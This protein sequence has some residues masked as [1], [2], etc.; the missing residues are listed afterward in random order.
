MVTDIKSATTDP[1]TGNI[2]SIQNNQMLFYSTW[3]AAATGKLLVVCVICIAIIVVVILSI[4]VYRHM[5]KKRPVT[6]DPGKIQCSSV[7]HLAL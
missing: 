7:I 4:Y 6:V 5:K 1:V 2:M 3:P